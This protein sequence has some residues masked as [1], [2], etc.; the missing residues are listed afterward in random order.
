MRHRILRALWTASIH[1]TGDSRI[2][3]WLEERYVR[4]MIAE[5]K[6]RMK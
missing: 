5:W 2:T 6:G 4:A 3:L 1:I